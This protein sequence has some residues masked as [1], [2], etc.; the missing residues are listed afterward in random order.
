MALSWRRGQ[1]YVWA[2]H[3]MGDIVHT[4]V[5]ISAQQAAFHV[6][7]MY[8]ALYCYVCQWKVKTFYSTVVEWNREGCEK[9]TYSRIR[10]YKY[11]CITNI[12]EH[13]VSYA[14]PDN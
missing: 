6:Y 3:T 9:E 11:S 10:N 2:A 14:T 12:D 7:W 1:D 5:A 13:N 4:S 8:E